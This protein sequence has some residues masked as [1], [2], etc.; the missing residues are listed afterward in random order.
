MS[1]PVENMTDEELMNMMTP[2]EMEGSEEPAEDNRALEDI[3]DGDTSGSD[4]EEQKEDVVEADDTGSNDTAEIEDGEKDQTTPQQIKEP[5]TEAASVE[6]AKPSEVLDYEQEYKKLMAPFKANGKEIKLDSPEEAVRLMQM[7][8]NYTKKMQAL[9]PNLKLMRMLENHGLMSE[10]KLTF[11]IDL[12]RKD[13]AAIQKFMHDGQID[14]MEID[15]ST[16]PEY[17]P[18]NHKVSDQEMQFHSV[19]GDVISTPVGKE[20]VSMINSHWDQSSKETLYQ[21]PEILQIIADQRANGIYDQISAEIE[22]RQTLGQLGTNL[23][24]LQAY[25]LVG[26]ALH[27]QGKLTPNVQGNQSGRRV[28]ETRVAQPSQK[29]DNGDRAKA[30]SP[31]R[32]APAQPRKAF[33]PFAMS[34]DEIMAMASPKF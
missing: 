12:N 7:G 14:P 31:T 4:E 25:K 22:R 28:I 17:K 23:P 27:A 3:L 10:E 8:A 20:T 32:S 24:F 11:L 19:L 18:G 34:D 6:T 30:A 9:T 16:A 5:E 29:S 33:D 15:A 1:T 21:E 2:P 26:D 13:P